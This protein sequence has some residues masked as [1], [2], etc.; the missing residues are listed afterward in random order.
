MLQP[1]CT[2]GQPRFAWSHVLLAV[3]HVAID[4]GAA[5]GA[6]QILSTTLQGGNRATPGLRFAVVG[7]T[8]MVLH[9]QLRRVGVQPLE[10]VAT[11]RR[12]DRGIASEERGS[13]S[14]RVAPSVVRQ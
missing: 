3:V 11:P 7:G 13:R 2:T 14:T 5:P 10:Q 4:P 8:G 1:S 12:P 6:Y 9:R